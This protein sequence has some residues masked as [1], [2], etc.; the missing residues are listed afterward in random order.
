MSETM[1]LAGVG[2]EMVMNAWTLNAVEDF[3]DM[4]LPL[5]RRLKITE[6]LKLDFRIYKKRSSP[7]WGQEVSSSIPG[8]AVSRFSPEASSP[9]EETPPGILL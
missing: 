3:I 7:P 5:V 2:L 8:L 9:E 4:G 6:R 1:I